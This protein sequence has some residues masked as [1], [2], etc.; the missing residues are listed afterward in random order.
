LKRRKSKA[1]ASSPGGPQPGPANPPQQPASFSRRKLWIFRAI[2]LI[3][4]PLLLLGGFELALRFAG[5]GF[6]TAFFKRARIGDTDFLVENDKFGLRFFPPA[7]AR[8]PAPVV[9][10]AKKVPGTYRIF[11]LGESAALGDP[12]PAYGPG[13][14]L[15]TLLQQRYPEAGFEVVCVAMTAINSHTV[16]PIAREC[17]R[18]EG[19]FWIVYM[20]N[21][22]FVG[23]FGATT[24]FGAQAPSTRYVRLSLAVQRLRLGQLLMALIRKLNGDSSKTAA[25]GGMKMFM[26]NQVAP[27]DP[28][29][30]AVE[31]NFEQNLRDILRAG[32]GSGAKVILNTV[33][34]NLKDCPPFA[35]YTN[36]NLPAADTAVLSRTLEQAFVAEQ[37]GDPG[38]AAQ[39]YEQAAKLEPQ[40]A[41]VHFALGSCQAQL[42]NYSAARE[43][44]ALARDLDAL[45]FRATSTLNELTKKM[46]EGFSD[47]GLVLVDAASAIATNSP[48]GIPGDES[49]YEHVHF[50]FDG[51]YRLALLWA[52]QV[53][54]FI[55]ASARRS[56]S[57][58]APQESCE[59]R[60][61]LTDWNR[62]A[63][64]EDMIRRLSEPPFTGQSGQAQ[65]LE[66]FRNLLKAVRQR[67]DAAGVASAREIY[68]EA[69]EAAP[70]DHRLH[71][72]FA[73]F[74]EATG[75]PQEAGE[76][77][78]QVSELIPQHHAA[79]FHQGRLLVRQNRLT[80]AAAQ[81][82]HALKLRPDLAEG[83]LELGKIHAIEGKPALALEDY[84]RERRLAPGDPRVYYH[85][86]KALS[87]LNRRTESIQQLREAIARKPDYW[88]AHYALGEELAFS[89]KIP[90]ARAEFEQVI[91]LQ[92]GYAMAHF[93]LGVA[94]AGQGHLEDALKQFE[95]TLRLDPNHKIAPQY[96]EKL[97]AAGKRKP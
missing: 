11:V 43:Q 81:L 48:I 42:T 75:D 9:M 15:Q 29:R 68:L 70:A 23:P 36:S 87:S 62:A 39:F 20:G 88:E 86:G 32:L 17:A 56:G 89:G 97:K 55:P 22:E 91:R 58:W 28:H 12:R 64:Y 34:V 1:G 71:E 74:L 76:Q 19:D 24:V 16:L 72:N 82:Q 85:M 45:P 3:G 90:E 10:H 94:L 93:N 14:Y 96:I 69:L 65:R 7:I 44:F 80:E 78:R 31:R 52:G 8:S 61:G 67:M 38:N 95:E 77:W 25:W 53:D 84:E 92:P 66:S 13:R 18:R 47:R 63:V 6:P 30:T 27:G 50:N 60:L 73:E 26:Q 33:A 79:F 40:S 49:F 2:A 5:Y 57:A 21:N 41:Q 51:N 46:G 59:R 4:L 37:K 35:S 54:H 83:W